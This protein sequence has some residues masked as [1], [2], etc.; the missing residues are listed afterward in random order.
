M[1]CLWKDLRSEAQTVSSR[2]CIWL[3]DFY[4]E[5]CFAVTPVK[6]NISY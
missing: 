3:V 1:L 5:N 2:F 4:D 6:Q